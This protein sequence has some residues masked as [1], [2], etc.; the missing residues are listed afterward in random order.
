MNSY[1]VIPARYSSTRLP[2]KPLCDLCGKP[3]IIHVAQR[4]KEVEGIKGVF[5]ATDDLRIKNVVQD[6]GFDCIMTRKEHPSG[7]DR[8]YEAASK[9]GFLEDD[10]IINVQGDQPLLDTKAVEKML[11]LYKK[12]QF[13]MTTVACKMT[14]NE[15]KDPNRVKVILDNSFKAIYFSRAQIPFDRDGI[16]K[17]ES[18]PYLRHLGLYCYSVSFLK[19]FVSWPE[20]RLEQIERLEQLRVIE[21][22]HTIGVT[23]VDS[24]PPEVDTEK[25]LELVKE[26]LLTN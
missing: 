7:T 15:A 3:M 12:G 9:I 25:D 22:G 23:I 24:A 17:G 21:N 5:I 4:A 8:I 2:G 26:L 19:R 11:S 13:S 6:F 1:I 16:L 14:E 18:K 20:G 10:V